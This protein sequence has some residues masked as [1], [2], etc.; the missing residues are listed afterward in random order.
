MPLTTS[1][2]AHIQARLRKVMQGRTQLV[3]LTLQVTQ[4]T[5]SVLTV[6]AVWRTQEDQDPIFDPAG[7]GG[8]DAK[9]ADVIALFDLQ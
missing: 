1:K 5:T 2:I 7:T 8:D 3:D 6:P 4:S 9:I